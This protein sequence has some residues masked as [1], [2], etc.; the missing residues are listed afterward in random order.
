MTPRVSV[1]SV[2]PVKGAA[3]ISVPEMTLDRVGPVG[4]R[5]WMLVDPDGVFLSQRSTPAMALLGTSI[6]NGNSAAPEF[7]VTHPDAPGS[8][9]PLLPLNAVDLDG[10]RLAV[11]IW[12]DDVTAIAPDP[13]ADRW[14]SAVLR[15]P[16]RVVYLPDSSIRP[17]D[18][19]WAPGGRVGFADGYPLLVASEASLADLNARLT[20]PLPMDRFRPNIVVTGLPAAHDEDRWRRIRIGSVGFVGV[21]ACARCSVT[22]VD[23][24]S[25]ERGVEPLRTLAEYRKHRGK[26]YFGQ[27]LVH[28][29]AGRLQ[30]GDP[31]R[32]L[33]TAEPRY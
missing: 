2:Y 30:V 3:G 33:E 14:F 25:G 4:D 26:V 31:V 11:R 1:L 5:R 12:S 18:P 23:Q 15:R 20:E 6:P 22:T 10:E 7:R 17:T 29:S 16:C 13:E 32:V 19:Q 27:N 24:S 28:D 21:R 9:G 8:P